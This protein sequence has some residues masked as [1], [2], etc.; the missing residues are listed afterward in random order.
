MS[1]EQRGIEP[2][3]LRSRNQVLG[4]AAKLGQPAVLCDGRFVVRDAEG[5]E[6]HAE[7]GCATSLLTRLEVMRNRHRLL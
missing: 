2:Q 5:G 7:A 3:G 1:G 4:R 6:Q